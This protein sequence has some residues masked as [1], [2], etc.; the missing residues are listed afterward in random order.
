MSFD[1]YDFDR[2]KRN[3]SPSVTRFG[4]YRALMKA[5]A[6]VVS[7]IDENTLIFLEQ[8]KGIIEMG[9]LKSIN[10]NDMMEYDG[11]GFIFGDGKIVIVNQA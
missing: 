3:G 8:L 9:G 1:E 4:D 2:A 6:A 5:Q 11:G 7:A 10:N